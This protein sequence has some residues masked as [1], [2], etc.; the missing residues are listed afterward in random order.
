MRPSRSLDFRPT[1]AKEKKI[2]ILAVISFNDANSVP[3]SRGKLCEYFGINERTVRK[4]SAAVASTAASTSTPPS[5]P[6]QQPENAPKQPAP[7][8]VKRARSEDV[9]SELLSSTVKPSPHQPA[10]AASHQYAG[11][12]GAQSQKKRKATDEVSSASPPPP[13][14]PPHWLAPPGREISWPRKQ[15]P[16]ESAEPS[17]DF[18]LEN[19]DAYVVA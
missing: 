13:P 3:Y 8:G 11:R 14:P 12:N 10:T 16:T 5:G 17:A 6:A 15:G 2:A 7:R 4:W 9:M 18:G 1:D 19:S